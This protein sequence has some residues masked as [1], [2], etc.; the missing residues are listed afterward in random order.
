MPS[1]QTA[2]PVVVVRAPFQIA[3]AEREHFGHQLRGQ[4]EAH[5]IVD[6]SDTLY[7]DAGALRLVLDV[8]AEYRSAGRSLVLCC[9]RREPMSVIEMTHVGGWLRIAAG[10]D[11]ARELLA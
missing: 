4:G 8:D 5:C 7:L 1:V 9:L 2:L 11:D 10:L 6:F 3:E